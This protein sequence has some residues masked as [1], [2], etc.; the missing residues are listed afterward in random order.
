MAAPDMTIESGISAFE[1]KHFT[2]AHQLL[3]P[4]AQEGNSDAQYRVAIMQQ[5][6][7]GVVKNCTSA[8]KYM[9][10]SA[11]QGHALAQHGLGFMYLQGECA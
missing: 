7:L 11:E 8:F 4:L 9:Q 10:A 5:N 3:S 2:K 6:G 1:A